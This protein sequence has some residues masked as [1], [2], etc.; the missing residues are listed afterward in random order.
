[1]TMTAR[2]ADFRWLT[3]VYVRIGFERAETIRTAKEARSFLFHRWPTSRG[4]A[5]RRALMVCAADNSNHEP[6]MSREA[7]I[8]ACIEARVLD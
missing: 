8:E 6:A 2:S 7:F 3:P 1:M 5:Y 4:P